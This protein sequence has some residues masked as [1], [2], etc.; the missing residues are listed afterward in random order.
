[1]I[2]L[3]NEQKSFCHFWDCNQVLHFRLLLIMWAAP[4]ILRDLDHNSRHNGHLN[5]I[6]SSLGHMY[7]LDLMFLYFLYLRVELLKRMV[8]LFLV[9]W[10][11]LHIVFPPCCINFH[12]HHHWTILLFSP[13]L[14][15]ILLFIFFLFSAI[16]TDIKWCLIM[17]FICIS[18]IVILSIFSCTC[19][20]S[21]CLFWKMSIQV[22]FPEYFPPFI[23][24]SFHFINFFFFFALQ[25]LLC[26]I[27]S[28]LFIFCI[29]LFCLMRQIQKILLQFLSK[30]DHI[31]GKSEQWLLKYY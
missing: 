23:K 8:V 20:L 18:L 11:N 26:L 29:G 28:H 12:S 5:V 25:K 4:F 24:L 17:V 21:I 9:F 13:H 15:Q 31:P 22:L 27:R 7:M 1:M 6:C 19:W 2:C 30:H 14:C 10:G 3:R 16:L